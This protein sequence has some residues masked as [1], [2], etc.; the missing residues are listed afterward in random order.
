MFEHLVSSAAGP[1]IVPSTLSS[2]DHSRCIRSDVELV[3]GSRCGC[4][5]ASAFCVALTLSGLGYSLHAQTTLPAPIFSLPAGTYANSVL[6]MSDSASGATIHY[7]TNGST[8][9]TSSTAY[10]GPIALNSSGTFTFKAIA[11][12][13]GNINSPVTSVTYT[14]HPTL[15]RPGFSPPGGSYTGTQTVTVSDVSRGVTIYYTTDGSTPTTSSA[16][17]SAPLTVSSSKALNAIAALSGWTNS[18]VAS[19][20]YTIGTM[21]PAPN[22]SLPAGTYTNSVLTMRDSTSGATIYYTTNGSTP[23]TSSARYTAP[24]AL[25]SSG[26]FTFKAMAVETGYVDSPVTTVTYTIHPSLTRPSFS[27]PGGSYTGTQT[28]TV[29]DVSRGVTIY[30][31]TDGGTPTTSS[32]VYSAPLTVKSDET[33]NAIAALSGWTNSPVASAVYNLPVV[34]LTWYAPTSSSDP[35]AGYNIYRAVS[36]SSTFQLLNSSVDTGTTYQDNTVQGGTSYTY[37]VE[38]VDTSGVQ[39]IP[40][41]QVI[42]TIP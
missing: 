9:T 4:R 20:A 12:E 22:F 10:T 25:N 13:T 39:S 30:Y 8:P 24:I 32:A 38:S 35:V 27:P 37:Y 17:Y 34:E 19:A 28:V 1:N 7:T 5:I 6:A 31:T 21:L 29:S 16:V 36:N 42:V 23:T 14:I 41:S 3:N 26:T 15:T 33:I 2:S 11:V 40:S 18:P